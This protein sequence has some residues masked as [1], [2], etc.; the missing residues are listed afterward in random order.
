MKDLLT[1]IEDAIKYI[2]NH[3]KKNEEGNN[4]IYFST[5][6]NLISKET[7]FTFNHKEVSKIYQKALKNLY[8][9]VIKLSRDNSKN[10]FIIATRSM[11]F[12]GNVAIYSN[13][14]NDHEIYLMSDS[15]T[16]M[17]KILLST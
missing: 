2:W 10:K 13:F 12:S 14:P 15:D 16:V 7:Y 17:L 9:N 1:E 11:E 5:I 8:P 6:V 4:F 3:P